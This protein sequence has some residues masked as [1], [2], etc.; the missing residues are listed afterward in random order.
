[1]DSF[2]PEILHDDDCKFGL[3]T[4][5]DL[6]SQNTA[7]DSRHPLYVMSDLKNK[8]YVFSSAKVVVFLSN[9]DCNQLIFQSTIHRKKKF[10]EDDSN[11]IFNF[12]RCLTIFPKIATADNPV[13]D[14]IMKV[15]Y[16]S[17]GNF[18]LIQIIRISTFIQFEKKSFEIEGF[19]R[20]NAYVLKQGPKGVPT[21]SNP[22]GYQSNIIICYLSRYF[23]NKL[24][25]SKVNQFTASLFADISP[26]DDRTLQRRL[27]N[28]TQNSQNL[29]DTFDI[30]GGYVFLI[31]GDGFLHY[32]DE[33]I[34]AFVWIPKCS[35]QALKL[36]N[37]IE[38]D[39]SFKAVDPQ[40]YVVPQLIYRN[41]GL[42]LALIVGPT[43]CSQLYALFY[44]S[45]QAID[46]IE[47]M[48]GELY[49]ELLAKCI[50]SD[51][52]SS[53]TKLQREYSIQLFYCYVHIIRSFGAHSAISILVREIL[54]FKSQIDFDDN[55]FRIIKTFKKMLKMGGSAQ[56]H[57]DK[58]V[59]ILGYDE[60]GKACPRDPRMEPLFIRMQKGV[61][62]STNHAER[63]H[64][65]VNE[66]LRNVK[67]QYK[68][69]GVLTQCIIKQ[70][71]HINQN[72]LRNLR[73]YMNTTKHF[74][75]LKIEED[76]SRKP[77]FSNHSCQKPKCND[78]FYYSELYKTHLPCVH[79][80]LNTYWSN[81]DMLSLDDFSIDEVKLDAIDGSEPI[82]KYLDDE[83]EPT[84]ENNEPPDESF[85]IIDS[86]AFTPDYFDN[87]Y[88]NMINRTF[89]QLRSIMGSK[90]KIQEVGGFAC[91]IQVQMLQDEEMIELYQNDI[92]DFII[93]LSVN[94]IKKAYDEKK[95][96]NHFKTK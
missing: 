7:I 87:I 57:Y 15:Y 56:K 59:S 91:Q 67:N 10:K 58:F 51:Q 96:Q 55:I 63:F 12:D 66:S 21:P 39:T 25:F 71:S 53:F 36:G 14:K 92:D 35:M 78:G 37:C 77:E 69:L 95:C 47:Q 30:L 74:A 93:E 90:I 75:Q 19:R 22:Q 49:E 11:Q 6:S 85:P 13:K 94:V 18:F 54:F 2:D 33:L 38:L 45:I 31:K 44:R 26:P 50:L 60:N 88:S 28:N 23:N 9:L 5:R 89:V 65:Y 70:I 16:D 3:R 27:V 52:H 64:H 84:V 79:E 32:E 83:F 42:P 73:D 40:V 46:Q 24:N 41:S 29:K 86:K 43:E 62:T 34:K 4:N 72:V 68:K 80:C 48:N 8:K 76:A 20:F 17:L 81:N 1:M 61:P 82:I